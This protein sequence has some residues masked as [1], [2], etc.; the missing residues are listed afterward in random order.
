MKTLLIIV[1]LYLTLILVQAGDG[2]RR[3][4]ITYSIG[5]Q[6]ERAVV[7]EVSPTQGS[8]D[9]ER[10]FHDL[11]PNAKLHGNIEIK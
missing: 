4:K 7:I 1:A 9:A 11:M 5:E 2:M 8:Y 6:T 3:F 10:Q